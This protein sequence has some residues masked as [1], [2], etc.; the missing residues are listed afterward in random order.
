MASA[1]RAD[2]N[3]RPNLGSAERGCSLDSTFLLQ[4]PR[5]GYNSMDRRNRTLG[6]LS[7]SPDPIATRFCLSVPS[8][9]LW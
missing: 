3:P 9:S 1:Y 4:S 5:M 6:D 8:V 2:R 7:V